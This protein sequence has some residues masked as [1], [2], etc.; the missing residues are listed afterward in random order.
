MGQEPGSW[1]L[2]APKSVICQKSRMC[3]PLRPSG[4]PYN[5]AAAGPAMGGWAEAGARAGTRVGGQ[6][7][8]P[9]LYLAWRSQSGLLSS[10]CVIREYFWDWQLQAPLPLRPKPG[11]RLGTWRL[12]VGGRRG[13]RPRLWEGAGREA[14]RSRKPGRGQGPL[15]VKANRKDCP[16]S[17][18]LR[19]RDRRRRR[20]A[21]PGPG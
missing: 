19:A 12:E 9:A 1:G 18:A 16:L 10:S 3:Q 5:P 20:A 17:S 4:A 8:P 21:A 15:A 7:V 2:P 6:V 13:K 14:L 11:G